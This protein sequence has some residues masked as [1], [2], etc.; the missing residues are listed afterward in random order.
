MWSVV[1]LGP[2]IFGTGGVRWSAVVCGI[3]ADP[4]DILATSGNGFCECG[5]FNVLHIKR[6]FICFYRFIL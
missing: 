6:D 3:Q 2:K 5:W 1:I 4:T